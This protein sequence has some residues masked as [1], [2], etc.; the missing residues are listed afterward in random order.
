MKKRS[1]SA[2]TSYCWSHV[3]HRCFLTWQLELPGLCC[4]ELVLLLHIY[5]QLR[6]EDHRIRGT[7]TMTRVILPETDG[8]GVPN[9]NAY[10]A[11][12]SKGKHHHQKNEAAATIGTRPLVVRA[13]TICV[14]VEE[15]LI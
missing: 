4:E 8:C 11:H 9:R 3:L 6:V 1:V 13:G 2:V 5:H 14:V 15:P 10:H 12:N 7:T